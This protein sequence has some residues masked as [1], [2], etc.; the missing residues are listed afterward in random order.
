VRACEAK[1]ER[2]AVSEVD[3]H[4]GDFETQTK[5]LFVHIARYITTAKIKGGARI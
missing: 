5:N 3:R 2:E 1:R 4:T